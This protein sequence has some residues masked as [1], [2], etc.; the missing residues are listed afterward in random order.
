MSLYFSDLITNAQFV[1]LNEK[2]IMFDI[3]DMFPQTNPGQSGKKRTEFA[4]C[5]N[6]T[7]DLLFFHC[8]YIIV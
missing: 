4:L 8:V 7:V 5:C 2:Q 1:I 6:Y 3:S